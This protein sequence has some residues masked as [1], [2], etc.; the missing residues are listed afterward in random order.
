[1]T[2]KFTCSCGAELSAKDACAGRKTEC[3]K[4]G[5]VMRIPQHST[6][7]ADD[8]QYIHFVCSCGKHIRVRA[9]KAG[10]N[11]GCPK[12]G[13]VHRVEIPDHEARPAKGEAEEY[14]VDSRLEVDMGSGEDL[15]VGPR[16]ASEPKS[17]SRQ[18]PTPAKTTKK[19]KQPA[20]RDDGEGSDA[21]TPRPTTAL[22]V[23]A[24]D[25][26]HVK[27]ASCG[28]IV[29]RTALICIHCGMD[30]RTGAFV[31]VSDEL[32]QASH[33]MSQEGIHAADLTRHFCVPGPVQAAI[34]GLFQV[35]TGFTLYVLCAGLLAAG[36]RLAGVIAQY[37]DGHNGMMVLM[38]G[39]FC[40]V[41]AFLCAGFWGCV[42]DGVFERLFGIERFLHHGMTHLIRVSSSLALTAPFWF[43]LWVLCARGWAWLLSL[44]LG[45]PAKT[46]IGLPLLVAAVA[47]G[48]SLLLVPILAI[49][50]QTG[51]IPAV[52][53]GTRFLLRHGHKVLGL[54]AAWIVA[55]GACVGGL[56]L[57]HT[58]AST[59][60]PETLPR[61]VY[62]TLNVLA[63]SVVAAGL[64]G[65]VSAALM[66]LYLSH[67]S[68]NE[69]L[70]AVQDKIK[71]P[72]CRPWPTRAAVVAALSLPVLF[73]FW[74]ETLTGQVALFRAKPFYSI[75]NR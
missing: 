12:C 4:C 67:Q 56:S 51:P 18:P 62:D 73:G 19:A 43:A 74:E 41:S 49:L 44:G 64:I 27:C 46:S 65:Q 52:V 47:A 32:D 55:A 17:G 40:L 5:R 37:A 14:L 22:K 50:E 70:L 42:K 71:G 31:S 16:P 35:V 39:G 53:S 45:W 54:A 11:V 75:V 2:I 26:E 57:L 25:H 34:A 20:P 33:H 58:V 61:L 48:L 13:K 66:A 23:D 3:P 8:V 68:D 69:H 1:M 28:G 63:I 7:G 6:G 10:K 9:E 24:G 30:Y 36:A 21:T 60:R 29:P 72:R 15:A 38:G 59:M